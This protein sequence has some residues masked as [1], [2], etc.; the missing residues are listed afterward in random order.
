[1]TDLWASYIWPAY[2]LTVGGMGA[3]LGWAWT[4]MRRAEAR[5]D[6]MK[7]R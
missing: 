7:R 1:M 6:E 5:A 4:T 2:V 3:L